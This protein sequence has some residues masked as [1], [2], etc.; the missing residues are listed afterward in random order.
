M[1]PT[2]CLIVCLAGVLFA[3][4][5]HAQ[6]NTYY[7]PPG[8]PPP[9]GMT[10]WGTVDAGAQDVPVPRAVEIFVLCRPVR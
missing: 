9:P 8:P 4:L 2:R 5:A 7:P 6:T 3:G 1:L 10:S